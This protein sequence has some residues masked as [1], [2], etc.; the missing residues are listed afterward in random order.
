[1]TPETSAESP[2]PDERTPG[3]AAA[4][5]STTVVATENAASVHLNGWKVRAKGWWKSLGE[6]LALPAMSG[7]AAIVMAIVSVAQ[8]WAI[9]ENDKA[10]AQ[11]LDAT[12]TSTAA[13]LRIADGL[14]KNVTLMQ[15]QVQL[16]RNLAT[17]R[18]VVRYAP[19][20]LSDDRLRMWIRN[21]GQ[22]VA[23]HVRVF[24]STEWYGE[25]PLSLISFGPIDPFTIEAGG[26]EVPYSVLLQHPL[27]ARNQAPAAFAPMGRGLDLRIW[28]S[29][30]WLD[31]FGGLQI[32][33]GCYRWINSST[34]ER[35][36]PPKAIDWVR[37]YMQNGL[38][39][40]EAEKE[41]ALTRKYQADRARARAGT[42]GLPW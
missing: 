13:T 21:E 42:E 15:E 11:N 41:A 24:Y 36:E 35:C 22:T 29:I 12:R 5:E 10:T 27:G 6:L 28:H 25:T 8:W 16:S 7:L 14:A 37:V 26:Q 19:F 2:G 30:R 33:E 4:P 1:M 32:L 20:G 17:A 34:W 3:S 39:K 18:L 23:R 31:A 9:A 38:N 40:V